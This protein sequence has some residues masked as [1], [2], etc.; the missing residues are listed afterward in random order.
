[1]ADLLST[2]L[3]TAGAAGTD[4]DPSAQALYNQLNQFLATL[5]SAQRTLVQKRLSSSF[6]EPNTTGLMG[7]QTQDLQ[8]VANIVQ[9]VVG[10]GKQVPGAQQA[11]DP[12]S[13]SSSPATTSTSA[14][15]TTTQVGSQTTQAVSAGTQ[16]PGSPWAA[17]ML[18]TYTSPQLQGVSQS[19]P[20]A[21][22][23]ALGIDP[24]KLQSEYQSYVANWHAG[25]MRRGGLLGGIAAAVDQPPMSMQ[26]F[27]EQLARAQDG[28]W[29]PAID[30]LSAIWQQQTGQPMPPDLVQQVV[31]SLNALPT[32]ERNQVQTQML[33][34][35]NQL[36]SQW[37]AATKNGKLDP[38]SP[39]WNP[40][41]A[42][43]QFT[44]QLQTYAPNVYSG[45]SSSGGFSGNSL[46]SSYY[47]AHPQVSSEAAAQLG[48]E[49]RAAIDLL[50]QYGITPTPDLISTMAK[51]GLTSAQIGNYLAWAH[52][53]VA[54]TPDLID[55]LVS[56]PYAD[57]SGAA[58]P[59]G[60]GGALLQSLPSPLKG[61]DWGQYQIAW[62]N[63]SGLWEKYFSRDPNSQELAWS[64]GK[65]PQ[66]IQDFIDNSPSDIHGVT[67]GEKAAEENF[68]SGLSTSSATQHA[69]SMGVD[70]SLIADLHQHLTAQEGTGKQQPG[71][72]GPAAATQVA[73]PPSAPPPATPLPDGTPRSGYSP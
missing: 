1:M 55:Q 51:S 22:A 62:G 46:I 29:Q 4:V 59:P 3:D 10:T 68:I 60:T 41:L 48:S 2:M 73:P 70:N 21:I 64:I 43:N 72:I 28:A 66:D 71:S 47:V 61:I 6:L 15:T 58:V 9:Q 57:P 31:Q 13:T 40:L 45:T 54:V 69:F 49:Q 56:L 34:M 23:A 63:I 33:N 53:R 39:S 8:N 67:I 52:G 42:Y 26:A 37:K 18:N 19:D 11:A 38:A 17:N 14:G 7:L 50:T 65:T 27:G 35:V 36:A 25:S 44:Q 5:T 12:P 16:E 30:A 24:S 32:N 20:A